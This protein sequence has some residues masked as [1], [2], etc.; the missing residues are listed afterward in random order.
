[1]DC[2]FCGTYFVGIQSTARYCSQECKKK[3][4]WRR[5][6]AY[7][8]AK[9]ADRQGL[10]PIL[11]D[12]G[13][14]VTGICMKCGNDFSYMAT[15][16]SGRRRKK[17]GACSP[18]DIDCALCGKRCK[19]NPGQIHCVKCRTELKL[20]AGDRPLE[21]VAECAPCGRPFVRSNSRHLYCSRR[22][23]DAKRP[24]NWN[25]RRFA[26]YGIRPER[27]LAIEIYERDG[28]ICR[29]CGIPVNPEV[30]VP[31]PFAPTQDHI[32]PLQRGGQHTRENVQLAHFY[33]NSEKQ[34][35]LI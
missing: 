11:T 26:K 24:S 6:S 10:N 16:Q 25:N 7:R 29:L 21:Q 35:Q 33:C 9:L 2:A 28:W 31:H 3:A 8:S 17:C 30:E 32:I 34:D 18:V 22:C 23:A 27:F 5:M 19:P 20:L 12:G 4:R 15:G 13:V 1:M 14:R